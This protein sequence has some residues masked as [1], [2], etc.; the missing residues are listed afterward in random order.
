MKDVSM[1]Y[2]VNKFGNIEKNATIITN[3]IGGKPRPR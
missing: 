1:V 2:C 3:V